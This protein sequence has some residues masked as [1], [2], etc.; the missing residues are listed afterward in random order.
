[1][2]SE[3][4]LAKSTA[5]FTSE[6]LFPQGCEQVHISLSLQERNECRDLKNALLYF[7]NFT[8]IPDEM[9]VKV[10]FYQK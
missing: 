8:N 1:M 6:G 3:V 5:F 7:A 2:V 4:D 10:F 9:L